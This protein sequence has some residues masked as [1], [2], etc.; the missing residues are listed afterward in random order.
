MP[1]TDTDPNYGW[2]NQSGRVFVDPV[3]TS[4]GQEFTSAQLPDQNAQTAAGIPPAAWLANGKVTTVANHTPAAPVTSSPS[5]TK[6]GPRGVRATLTVASAKPLAGVTFNWGDNTSTFKLNPPYIVGHTYADPGEYTI[7]M[8][9]KNQTGQDIETVADVLIDLQPEITSATPVYSPLAGGVTVT[10]NGRNFDYGTGQSVFVGATEVSNP[11]I[12]SDTQLT[13]STP[14]KTAGTYNLKVE[15]DYGLS[16]EKVNAVTYLAL[17]TVSGISPTSGGTAG[18]TA[19]TVTGTG[20]TAGATTPVVKFGGTNATSVVV[21]S[22]TSITCVS[23]AKTAGAHN[24][25]VTTDGGTSTG[26]NNFTY[27]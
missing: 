23:P 4:P 6:V 19:V 24:V 2:T 5:I 15:T 1:S 8:T 12:V 18:G 17:P 20:F 21:V 3:D 25:T 26:T 13:F 22:A 7:T 14:T 11:T 16:Y 10:V 9:A 27:S